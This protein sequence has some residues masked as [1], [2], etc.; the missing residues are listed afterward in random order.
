MARASVHLHMTQPAVTKVIANLEAFFGARLFDRSTRG[1]DITAFGAELL[2]TGA[3]V[4]DEL[5]QGARNIEALAD[6]SSGELRIGGLVSTTAVLLPKIIQRFSKRYPRVVFEVDDLP[7]STNMQS[8]LRE[9]R[10]DVVLTRLVKPLSAYKSD[11][12]V[13]ILFDDR[14][15][16]VAGKH[17]KWARRRKLDIS[18]LI[19]EPWILAPSHTWNYTCLA[20]AFHRHSLDMPTAKVVTLSMPLRAELVANGPYVTAI[21]VSALQSILLRSMLEV[22]PVTLPK[23]LGPVAI[24]T[25]KNRTLVPVAERFIETA[26]EVATSLGER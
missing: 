13:D 8:V 16:I 10:Y 15:V 6:P 24:L 22:L 3:S 25:L 1:V 21:A 2:K 26:R 20:E 17:S 14:I 5:R 7:A 9:R 4:F 12:S 11:A 19:H 18:E 23:R